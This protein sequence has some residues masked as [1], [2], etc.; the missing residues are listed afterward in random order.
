MRAEEIAFF[1]DGVGAQEDDVINKG[2][3]LSGI[4]DI[5]DNT[6]QQTLTALANATN[7]NTN[8]TCRALTLDGTDVS[9]N[10]SDP[11]VLLVQG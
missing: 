6:R 11:A 10:I 1:V 2:F 9:V 8:I 5:D 7:N 3:T 4:T